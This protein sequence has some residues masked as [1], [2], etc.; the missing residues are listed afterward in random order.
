MPRNCRVFDI[1]SFIDLYSELKDKNVKIFIDKDEQATILKYLFEKKKDGSYIRKDH[2][3]RILYTIFT[4]GYDEDLYDWELKEK[5]VTGMKFKG[6][7]NMRIACKEF[8]EDGKKIVMICTL[9]KRSKSGKKNDKKMNHSY[10]IIG[11]YQ[12]DFS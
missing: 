6:N 1:S 12:Y 2:L 8:Y 10:A 11:N 9:K 7:S 4:V 5:N 3:F